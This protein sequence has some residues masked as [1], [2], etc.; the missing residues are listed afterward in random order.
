MCAS[1]ASRSRFYL[2]VLA[3]TDRWSV[4]IAEFPTD[5]WMSLFLLDAILPFPAPTPN[6][7]LIDAP[8]RQAASS[9]RYISFAYWPSISAKDK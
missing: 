2:C 6:R 4:N 7:G 9:E 8:F 1:S 5:K 3:A